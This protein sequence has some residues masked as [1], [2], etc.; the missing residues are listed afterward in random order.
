[1]RRTIPLLSIALLAACER[2]VDVDLNEGPSRLVVEARLEYVLENPDSRQSIT[3]RT[4]GSYFDAS[5]PPP[6]RNATVRVTD[7]TGTTFP[8]LEGATPGRYETGNL[9]VVAG[10]R[11]TLQIDADGKRYEATERAMTVAPLDS[12]RFEEP[13]PGR[14]SGSGG[15]RATIYFG[16]PGGARNYYLWDQYVDG[17][18]QLGPD[19]SFKMRLISNDDGFDGLPINAFQPFEGIEIQPG[20]TVL[21]RQIGLSEALFRYFFAFSDQVGAD[22]SPFGVPPASLRGNVA[23]LTDPL[24]PALGYF[25]VAQVSELSAVYQP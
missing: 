17:V 18:R 12:L 23:N 16:E 14:F 2:V 8:F 5:A 13:R 24:N 4:T 11:Y 25:S 6:V 15:V 22:G 1:M 21:I 19:S 7:E 10:R 20:S 9:M 3:L